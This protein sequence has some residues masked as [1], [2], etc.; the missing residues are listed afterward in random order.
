MRIRLIVA[1]LALVLLI[2]S[3]GRS[4]IT[5]VHESLQY[6]VGSDL[7]GLG[8]SGNG[9]TSPWYVDSL[10]DASAKDSCFWIVK[11]TLLDFT[12]AGSAYSRQAGS[13]TV[14]GRVSQPSGYYSRM[15]R[16]V[17]TTKQDTSYSHYWVSVFMDL[18]GD[19]SASTWVGLRFGPQIGDGQALMMGKGYGLT[20]YTFGGGYHGS[21]D[22]ECSTTNW[23]VGPVWLLAEIFN[24]GDGYM[25]INPTVNG[26]KTTLDT[27]TADAKSHGAGSNGGIKYVRFEAGGGI[28]YNVYFADVR[29]DTTLGRVLTGVKERFQNFVATVYSLEQNYPNPFNPTTQIQYSVPKNGFVTL[30]VYN[31]LGEEVATLF[32][33]ARAQGNY[34]ATF[35]GSKLASGVYFYRLQAGTTQ[36]TKK[37]VLMK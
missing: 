1:S 22:N 9:W 18:V 31:L 11:D 12:L 28:P 33:G 16:D 37:L 14:V 19:S 35:D 32:S 27:A 26:P 2:T 3:Q 23:D 25:W 13:N 7:T 21:A 34:V 6:P 29:I 15:Q 36:I 24:K 20:V 17:D 5:L 10:D 8:T 4:Q 30:K